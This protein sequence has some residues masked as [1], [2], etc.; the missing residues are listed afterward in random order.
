MYYSSRDFEV[1]VYVDK[2][3]DVNTIKDTITKAISGGRD[4]ACY[5]QIGHFYSVGLED[6]TVLKVT[7]STYDSECISR[8]WNYLND[9]FSKGFSIRE[10]NGSMF[11]SKGDSLSKLREEDKL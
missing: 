8:V 4:I 7:F 1:T 10:I 9:N 2:A 5:T 3:H 6:Y 11:M